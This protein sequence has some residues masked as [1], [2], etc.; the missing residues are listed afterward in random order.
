MMDFR[1]LRAAFAALALA[2]AAMLAVPAPASAQSVNPTASSVK[3][4]QLLKALQGGGTIGGRV[5]IPDPK[6]GTLIQPEG[7]DWRSFHQGTL[8]RIGAISILGMLALLVVFYL[9]RG[10]ITID[11]GPSGRTI[12]RFG[13]FERFIHWLTAGSFLALALTGL[14][15]TFGKHLL[16]PVIGPEAFTALSQA[17]KY[18]HNY[19]AFPFMLGILLMFLVWVKDN[20][21]D[22]VDL[23]WAQAGG[24]LFSKGVHP[25][26]KRFNGGQKM[27]FWLVIVGG[28]ALSLSGWHL[29]FPFTFGHTVT[30]LQFWNVIHSVVGVLLIAA[31]LAH[32]YIGSIGMEGAFDAMG[33]G[34]V[35]LNWAKE[36]HSLWVAEEMA[37]DRPGPAAMQPAE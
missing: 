33:S 31:M 37:K 14:N 5:S 11:S 12:T 32:A 25:P 18:V 28:A 20:I 13:S 19:L 26:A 15:I 3:E 29:L 36:H 7:R 22:R 2:I 23:A 34:E 35:D 16:L 6:A 17:G 30:D 8:A 1:T 21:P 27:I 10:R 4:E 9:V 24:G